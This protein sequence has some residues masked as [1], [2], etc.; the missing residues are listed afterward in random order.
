MGLYT[1]ILRQGWTVGT[2]CCRRRAVGVHKPH[3]DHRYQ[4]YLDSVASPSTYAGWD[5][6]RAMPLL[7]LLNQPGV[8]LLLLLTTDRA[9]ICTTS[10]VS[11]LAD[12]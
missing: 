12:A 7:Q 5:C 4:V 3:V 9:A 1:Q 10:M 2:H 11:V 8:V 6:S